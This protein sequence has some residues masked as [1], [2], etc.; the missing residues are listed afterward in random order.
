MSDIIHLLSDSIANQIAAGEVIQ[1]PASVVKELMENAVDADAGHIQVFIKDAGKSLVQIIDDGL[2]MSET[3]ARM[4]F[5]RHATS[6]ISTAEDL[7]S[8]KT[9]GFRGEAL[10]SIVSVAQVELKTCK[11]GENLGTLIR[12]SGSELETQE[13]IATNPGSV[14]SVKNLFFNIPVRRKFLKSNETEFKN[15]LTEFERIALINPHISFN[16][17]HNDTEVFN[18]PASILRQRI[19]N[20]YGKNINNHLLPL[21]VETS[22]IRISGFIGTPSSARKRG[23]L[24]YFFVNGRYMKHPYFHRAVT[25]AFEPFI[26]A[27]EMPNYF[28]YF[29]VD[30]SAIDV[31]IHPTKTEIKFENEQ[32]IWPIIAASIKEAIGK[33][34]AV[35]SIE[36]D[37]EGAIEIPVYEKGKTSNIV[38]KISLNQN[39]NPFRDNQAYKTPP[40]RNWEDLFEKND[41]LRSVE[42]QSSEFEDENTGDNGQ[43]QLFEQD[44]NHFQY[45]GKYLITPLKSG[46]VFIHQRRAHIRILFDDYLKRIEDKQ[47]ISQRLLFPEIITLTP[48]E[49]TILPYIEEDLNFLGFDL[50]NLGNNSYSINGIPSELEKVNPVETLQLMLNKALDTGCEIKEEICDALALGLAKMSAISHGKK[51]TEEEADNLIAKLFASKSPNYTPDGKI[52]ISIINDDELDKRFK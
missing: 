42:V 23:A 46:L 36:F 14:F 52:I 37:Q 32:A 49:A 35:P 21:N 13:S 10:A 39:Y 19:A 8:L 44:Y 12:I 11:R 38:P 16:L 48:K 45:K 40:K 24:Q 1:R 5:E 20:I 41:T 3:D 22:L 27:N 15:I 28:I 43:Q 6:K 30:P 29:N 31:N 18:L 33:S 7:F 47:G 2:G 9:M 4:A 26:P 34:N 50:A 17:Y 51:L 25:T